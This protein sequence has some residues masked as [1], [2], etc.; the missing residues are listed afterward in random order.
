[1]VKT[2]WLQHSKTFSNKSYRVKFVKI[3][4]KIMKI[5]NLNSEHSDPNYLIVDCHE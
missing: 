5:I 2:S 3:N 1:M 4:L